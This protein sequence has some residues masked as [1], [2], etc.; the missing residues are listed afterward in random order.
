LR[1]LSARQGRRAPDFSGV[2][3]MFEVHRCVQFVAAHGERPGQDPRSA[4]P[5]RHRQ[6]RRGLALSLPDVARA[7]IEQTKLYK[8]VLAFFKEV[9]VLIC[10]AASVSPFPH[11]QLFVEE[12]NGERM[13]TYYALA[14]HHLRADHGAVLLPPC[15]R[16]AWTTAASPSASR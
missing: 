12:I 11:S 10:P 8:R 13:P 16:A 5:Q 6:H 4:R 7:H 1:P 15:C 3:E 14:G 9:D 2:H